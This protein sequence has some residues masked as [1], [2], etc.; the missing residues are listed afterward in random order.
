AIT[1]LQDMG[2]EPFLISSS[3]LAVMAQR[4]VRLLCPACREP[5]DA[6]AAECELLGVSRARLFRARGCPR[7]GNS[8]YRGR[9]G[10]Y[11]FV[12]VDGTRRGMIHGRAGEQAMVAHARSRAPGIFE[13]GCRRVLAGETTLEEVLR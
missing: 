5:C 11:E 1:R 13:D 2:I 3:L 12:Q 8:G 10:I 9:T 6:D 7:C 4:L